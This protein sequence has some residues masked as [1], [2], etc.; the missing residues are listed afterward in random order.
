MS[1][2]TLSP[3]STRR[4]AAV[5]GCPPLARAWSHGH[6]YLFAAVTYDHRH[7]QIDRCAGTWQ[8]DPQ[9]LHYTS[10]LTLF[11]DLNW[12]ATELARVALAH[13]PYHR[14]DGCACQ[15]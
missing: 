13:E 4:L 15:S 10:C 6:S 9:P 8:E 2:Q 5:T 3:R 14:E 12:R 11:P 7:L 1:A